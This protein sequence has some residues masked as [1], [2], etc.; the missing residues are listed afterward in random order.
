VEPFQIAHL[1]RLNR[2]VVQ[3]IPAQGSVRYRMSIDAPAQLKPGLTLTV[4]WLLLAPGLPDAPTH[5]ASF[6]A[7]VVG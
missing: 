7:Q 5:R 4:N 6:D 3:A 1:F 2:R